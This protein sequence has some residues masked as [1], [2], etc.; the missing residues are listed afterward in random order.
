MK[1][2]I[3][4]LALSSQRPYTSSPDQDTA[5]HS[6]VSTPFCQ[7][8]QDLVVDVSHSNISNSLHFVQKQNLLKRHTDCS[9]CQYL[10]HDQGVLEHSFNCHDEDGEEPNDRVVNVSNWLTTIGKKAKRKSSTQAQRIEN[11]K[12]LRTYFVVHNS[13]SIPFK[14]L[15]GIPQDTIQPAEIY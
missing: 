9:H 5:N 15:K 6:T 12:Q 14:E 2:P 4:V 10:I 3:K 11:S 7:L 1:K 8:L 13:I